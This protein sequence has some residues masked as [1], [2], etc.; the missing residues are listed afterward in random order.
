MTGKCFLLLSVRAAFHGGRGWEVRGGGDAVCAEDRMWGRFREIERWPLS[1]RLIGISYKNREEKVACVILASSWWEWALSLKDSRLLTLVGGWQSRPQSL[2]EHCYVG[3][4]YNNRIEVSYRNSALLPNPSLPQHVFYPGD[5][6]C[7]EGLFRQQPSVPLCEVSLVSP[8]HQLCVC[9]RLS[10]SFSS[11]VYVVG[12]SGLIQPSSL[13]NKHTLPGRVDFQ[14]L[15]N[16]YT[17]K[18]ICSLF[19]VILGFFF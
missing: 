10:T 11:S 13:Q 18:E 8:L 15:L 17:T 12:G 9:G 5:V 16:E 4:C 2:E 1:R 3:R 14:C 19:T 6:S 7:S